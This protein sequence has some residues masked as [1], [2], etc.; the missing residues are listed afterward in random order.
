MV[1]ETGG[2]YILLVSVI[3]NEPVACDQAATRPEV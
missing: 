1:N 3:D 2:F